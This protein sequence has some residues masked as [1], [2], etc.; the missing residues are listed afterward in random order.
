MGSSIGH[1]TEPHDLTPLAVGLA[2]LCGLL[3]AAFSLLWS[4]RLP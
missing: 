4:S 3:A 1:R 2:L